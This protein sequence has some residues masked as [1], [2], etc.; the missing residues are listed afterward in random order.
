VAANEAAQSVVLGGL[1]EL[2]GHRVDV[3]DAD[4]DGA[5]V[6]G[7]KDTVGPRAKERRGEGRKGKGLV[8]NS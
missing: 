6:I 7:G 5:E 1:V 4:L 3:S 2:A 8:E